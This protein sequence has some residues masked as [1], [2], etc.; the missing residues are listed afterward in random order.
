MN[1]ICIA[2]RG[3]LNTTIVLSVMVSAAAA[4]VLSWKDRQFWIL[5]NINSPVIPSQKSEQS[6]R[7]RIRRTLFEGQ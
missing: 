6:D 2:L 7:R 1:R 4:A 3:L 5:W